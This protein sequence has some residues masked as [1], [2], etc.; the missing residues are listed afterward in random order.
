MNRV[1]EIRNLDWDSLFLEIWSVPVICPLQIIATSTAL[2][3]NFY[4]TRCF[5]HKAQCSTRNFS[6]T[7]SS[8]VVTS[9]S[10]Y[11][12]RWVRAFWG[13]VE[14]RIIGSSKKRQKATALHIVSHQ[15]PK[16]LSRSSLS[17][18]TLPLPFQFLPLISCILGLIW[19]ALF[20]F[21]EEAVFYL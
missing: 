17:V 2:V 9:L 12:N 20:G 10:K 7:G 8:N 13:S 11:L 18:I 21:W 19:D 4:F 1:A 6:L 14:L 5:Y 16:F 15:K 3:V